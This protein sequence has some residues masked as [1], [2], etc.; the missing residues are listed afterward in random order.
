M[1]DG[2]SPMAGVQNIEALK[3]LQG[4]GVA[5]DFSGTGQLVPDGISSATLLQKARELS[6]QADK[7]KA[8]EEF[9]ALF[10]KELLKQVF[11]PQDFGFGEEK[12]STTAV[13]SSDLLVGQLALE[14]ARSRALSAAQVLPSE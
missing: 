8:K 13:F 5:P 7:E 12:N 11:K 1:I 9:L 3:A 2:I 10:Y 6:K 14:L 4:L